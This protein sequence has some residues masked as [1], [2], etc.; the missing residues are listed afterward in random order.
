MIGRFRVTV[1]P[2]QQAMCNTK[3]FFTN[4]VFA[5]R[6]AMI[7]RI[8]INN[9][10]KSKEYWQLFFVIKEVLAWLR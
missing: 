6:G 10:Y 9:V 4:R 1:W 7:V 8:S 3:P 2:F 5:F